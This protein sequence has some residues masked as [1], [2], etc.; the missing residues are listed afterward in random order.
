MRCCILKPFLEIAEMIKG[1]F[2]ADINHFISWL[3]GDGVPLTA[4]NKRRPQEVGAGRTV[5]STTSR[6]ILVVGGET[7]WVRM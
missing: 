3:G 6:K 7:V 4:D 5:S 2:Q 1:E